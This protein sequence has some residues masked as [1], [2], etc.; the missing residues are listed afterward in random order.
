MPT[1]TTNT[2]EISLRLVENTP[3][4]VITSPDGKRQEKPPLLMRGVPAILQ[5]RLFRAGGLV[6]A[7]ELSALYTGFRLVIANDFDEDTAPLLVSDESGATIDAENDCIVLPMTEMNTETL[8]AIIGVKDRLDLGAELQL[9]KPAL[10]DE[11]IEAWQFPLG[12]QN[13]LDL[14]GTATPAPGSVN[15]Y[16]KDETYSKEE[17]DAAIAAAGGSST[18]ILDSAPTT[19]TEG[20]V[21][22]RA[23]VTTTGDT[24]ICAAIDDTDPTAVKYTWKQVAN[25]SDLDGKIPATEKGAANGVATLDSSG[26]VPSGQLPLASGTL[27]GDYGVVRIYNHTLYGITIGNSYKDLQIY[28]PTGADIANR[29][30]KR[31]IVAEN[32]NTAVTA[33]LTDANRITLTAA[34]QATARGVLGMSSAITTIP[35]ATSAYSLLDATATTNNHSWHYVHEP[36]AA[37]TYTLPA[38]TDAT[39]VH[40]I[41]LKAKFSASVLTYSFLDS[42]G[43]TVT[44][45]PMTG[46]IADGSVVEF[47]CTWETLVNQWVIEPKLLNPTL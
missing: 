29:R 7:A 5:I 45:L 42:E 43:G 9:F 11:P 17:T 33:A 2:Y 37:P 46:T 36:A 3:L 32:L 18:L 21:S 47:R 44:P 4:A 31:P 41:D 14:T 20:K 25:E 15:Y 38:V 40:T 27:N 39:V 8:E 10:Q 19:S 16:S 35:A 13:R 1:S 26:T 23:L 28:P 12:V 34:Q 30:Y 6:K 22:Q 24:Y